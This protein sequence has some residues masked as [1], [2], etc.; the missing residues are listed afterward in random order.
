[1]PSR[2]AEPNTWDNPMERL[3]GLF[4]NDHE[5]QRAPMGVPGS[6][7][8]RVHAPVSMDHSGR[9]SPPAPVNTSVY[10][11]I[12]SNDHMHHPHHH[13]RMVHHG[14]H[15]SHSPSGMENNW[16]RPP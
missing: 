8:G 2:L 5:M 6:I 3:Q 15:M 14:M 10:P 16:M 13:P 1:M 7:A 12:R 9:R 11:S 4:R